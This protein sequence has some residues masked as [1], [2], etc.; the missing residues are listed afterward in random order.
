MTGSNA[1]ELDDMKAA[2]KTLD[3]RLDA[4]AALNLHLF[5]DGKLDKMRRGLRPLVW[6][7]AIQ[8]AA[9]ALLTLWGGSF[10][11]D[12]RAV[13]HLLIAGLLVHAAG[14][15]MIALGTLMQTMIAR[16]DYSA[17]VLAIQRQ[18]AQLR[19]VYVRAGVAVGLPWCVLWVP[20]T[21]VALKS[22]FGPDLYLNAPQ[23]V[24]VNV[25]FGIVCILVTLAFL[26]WADGRP[27]VARRLDDF[28]AGRSIVRAQAYLDEI[29]RFEQE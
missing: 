12:Y 10:W 23:M 1:M 5:K 4:Q 26:R 21:I 18:L 17:P 20:F 28:A 29:A 13:P 15:S 25:G 19:K 8:I 7:Q 27:R 3:Q 24:R 16:I 22:V 9:G 6:G 11:V 2:W 14:I